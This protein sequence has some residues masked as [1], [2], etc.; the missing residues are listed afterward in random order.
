L[1]Y[2]GTDALVNFVLAGHLSPFYQKE[3]KGYGLDPGE[4]W[5]HAVGTAICSQRVADQAAP[6]LTGSAFTCGLLHCIGKIILNTYVAEEFTRLLEM[7][8]KN[9]IPF[10]EAEEKTLGISHAEVGAQIAEHWGLPP[11]IVASIRYYQNPMR[12]GEYAKLVS[13]VHVGNILC[14]SFGIGVGS[15]GLAYIFHPGALE[16]LK[17]KVEDLFALSVGIHDQFKN[18]ESLINME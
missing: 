14:V 2:I 5:K 11:E 6:A 9:A 16:L 10:I 1:V 17:I 12:A 18:A 3:Q 8:E 4:L 15:D 13:V 7:V